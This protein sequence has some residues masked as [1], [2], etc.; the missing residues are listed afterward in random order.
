ML[1]DAPNLVEKRLPESASMSKG[2]SLLSHNEVL[3]QSRR[4]MFEDI[5][6]QHLMENNSLVVTQ[7]RKVYLVEW[8]EEECLTESGIPADSPALWQGVAKHNNVIDLATY[9]LTCLISPASNV[10]VDRIFSLVTTIKTKSRNKTQIKLLDALV[11]IRSHPLNKAIC[12]NDFES[13]VN[14][15]K[16][17]YSVDLY[18][19]NESSS[20]NDD[21][22]EY[23]DE[24]LHVLASIVNKI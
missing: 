18:G 4:G 8:C 20:I 15:I 21:E 7:Y 3:S 1:Q 16:L 2:L 9:A 23:F 5:P 6:Y 13:A 22:T 12:S 10:I 14:M 11:R 24:I 19:K 17:P